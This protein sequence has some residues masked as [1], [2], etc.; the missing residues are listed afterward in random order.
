MISSSV[1]SAERP[2]DEPDRRWWSQRFLD[3][4]ESFGLGSRLQRGRDYART[5]QVLELDLEPGIALAKVQGSRF[6]PYRVRI[7]PQTFSEHQ[8][9]RA[10][11]A[12]AARALTLAA[13]LAGEMPDDIEEILAG[14]KLALLP[15][16]YDELRAS[17]T[18]PDEANPCKHTAAVYYT[19]AERFDADP[20]ALF[21]LRG[22]TREELLDA[23]RARR[24]KTLDRSRA[25]AVVSAADAPGTEEAAPP[26]LSELLDG[27]WRAGSQ[28]DELRVSPLAGECPDA[29]LRWL[30][31]L[32]P[33]DGAIDLGEL[34]APGDGAID[35]GEPLTPGD[36]AIDL[37]ELLAPAYARL[38]AGAER[39]A[40][41]D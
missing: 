32:T 4:L 33:G 37:G 16:S 28:L 19:L 6:T 2:D 12:I 3:L 26:P 21:T 39:R 41:A 31:P 18:C 25:A 9:R 20:F 13:L 38:A 1:S 11:K 35:L 40:L 24:S 23:L 17:C 5:G 29:L 7:R 34:Q 14:A 27:F 36:G 22:R 10:E 15:A 8:W 30:G